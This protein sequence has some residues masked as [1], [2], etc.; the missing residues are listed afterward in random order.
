M[1]WSFNSFMS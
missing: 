1:E